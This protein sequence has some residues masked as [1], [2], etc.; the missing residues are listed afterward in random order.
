M[1][2]MKI[3][4]FI[5]T[6]RKERGLTQEALGE[7][8]GVTNKTVSRWE[9]GAYMPDIG[10]LL[11]LSSLLGVSVNELL[12]GE[13]IADQREFMEQADKNLVKALS[14]NVFTY[15]E[16]VTYFK[17]K[18]LKE[19]IALIVFFALLWLLLWAAGFW[20]ESPLLLGIAA[21]STLLFRAC[22]TNTMMIYVERKA[23]E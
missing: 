14:E 5:A 3:G 23:F 19:H 20:K 17:K 12:S 10:K 2:Q 13:R 9:T 11:E 7:K 1:D 21:I 6:L 22:I 8:L 4:T 15:K 16:K 18:W